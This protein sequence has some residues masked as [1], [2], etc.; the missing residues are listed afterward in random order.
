MIKAG[1]TTGGEQRKSARRLSIQYGLDLALAYIFAVIGASAILI[2]LRGHTG[3]A[4]ADFA[5]RNTATVAVLVS[6]GTIAASVGG[7]LILAPTLRWYVAGDEPTPEQRDAV[8]KIAGR[9]SAVLAAVC[10][11]DRPMIF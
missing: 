1:P 10:D 4:N 2:P 9:Q 6:L 11:D 3:A 7:A 5:E 8:I